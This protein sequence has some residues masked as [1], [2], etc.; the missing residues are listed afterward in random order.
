VKC[1]SAGQPIPV[2]Q[3]SGQK[4]VAFRPTIANRAPLSPVDVIQRSRL[5][6][7]TAASRA[8]S[9][10]SARLPQSAAEGAAQ[11]R[12]AEEKAFLHGASEGARLGLEKQRLQTETGAARPEVN[13]EIKAQHITSVEAEQSARGRLADE[14]GKLKANEA[15][16][17]TARERAVEPG[18]ERAKGEERAVESAGSSHE[19]AGRERESEGSRGGGGKGHR[20]E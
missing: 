16:G 2:E 11:R 9:Q 7:T 13:K 4:I 17:A 10:S 19:R 5:A 1:S 8:L 14:K 15:T 3:R 6:G 12:L 20:G 18:K